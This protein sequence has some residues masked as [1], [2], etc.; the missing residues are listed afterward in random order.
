MR[1]FY[2][3]L[4]LY[5]G[6][7][8]SLQD[9]GWFWH[10]SD[11]HYD[12]SYWSDQL[13]CNNEVTSPGIYGDYWCDSPWLLI[14]DSIESM[15]EIRP[16]VDFLLWT[17]DN[18]AHISDDYLSVNISMGILQ[19][20][21]D[22][23]QRNFPDVPT[24]ATLGNHD[25]FPNNQFPAENSEIYDRVADMW[26]NWINDATEIT[27]FRNGAYY[28]V[29]SKHGLRILGLNTNIYYTS[30]K[31]TANMTDPAGQF[32]WLDQQLTAAKN[33]N[34][35]VLITAH[36]P[37]GMHTPDT[38]LWYYPHFNDKFIEII[39]KHVDN[40]VITAMYYGHDH[41]DGFKIFYKKDG[42]T[43]FP[44]FVAPS[45]TPWRFKAGTQTGPPHNP[46]V[47]LISYDR[48]TGQPINILMY[49][50]N[51]PDSNANNRTDWKLEYNFT[52]A[53]SVDDVTAPSLHKLRLRMEEDKSLIDMYY[54]FKDVSVSNPPSCNDDCKTSILCGFWNHKPDDLNTCTE[55]GK[56]TDDPTDYA[57][58]LHANLAIV[59]CLLLFVQH[60]LL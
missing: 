17:G 32:E 33:N 53:Y 37:P 42:T 27:R 51:L 6:P 23:L 15:K 12:F 38:I 13:S 3:I 19:N 50:I 21:T 45:V 22:E 16:D 14:K 47:R 8:E 31:V 43:A 9:I 11:F 24:Y 59:V 52:Q 55:K 39:N 44:I 36:I 26:T 4:V 48:A 40:D 58:H 35:K 5:T 57:V 20:I 2:L 46:G 1:F 41:S 54:K 10:A 30:D 28:S 60:L 7:V 56:T 49:Y 34:E 25:Y 18:V 29:K